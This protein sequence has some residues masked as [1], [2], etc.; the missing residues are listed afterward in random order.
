[1]ELHVMA[2]LILGLRALGFVEK[3]INDL[4]LYVVTGEEHYRESLRSRCEL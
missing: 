2:R 3:T 1:M 4:M